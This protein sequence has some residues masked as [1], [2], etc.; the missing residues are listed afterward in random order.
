LKIK[1][2]DLQM[3]E[4]SA[5]R[6]RNARRHA[7]GITTIH[8]QLMS[9]MLYWILGM[10]LDE[11]KLLQTSKSKMRTKWKSNGLIEIH[12][13]RE[14]TSLYILEKSP[15]SCHPID[16][17]T[18]PL[19]FQ[20]DRNTLGDPSILTQ[21]TSY[22]YS[23]NISRKLYTSGGSAHPSHQQVHQSSFCQ[24]LMAETYHCVWTIK[25][26]IKSPL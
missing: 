5:L 10:I 7:Q 15:M 9:I 12:C 25:E 21:R 17:L 14:I 22:Q 16:H 2:T 19:R 13:S 18:M 11:L 20:Q 1:P 23:K 26:S 8:S 24:S 6:V 3:E 4:Y